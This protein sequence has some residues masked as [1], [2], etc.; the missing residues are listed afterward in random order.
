RTSAAHRARARAAFDALGLT[1]GQPKVLYVLRAR[2]GCVQRELAAACQ[3]REPTLTVLLRRLEEKG[4]VV[5]RHSM[6]PGS[7][8]AFAVYLTEAGHSISKEIDDIVEALE[9]ESLRGFTE[10]EKALLF[11][12]LS[13]AEENLKK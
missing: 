13:R 11:S 5:K 4:F 8:N 10:E 12:L 2:Q 6:A 1:E 7:K 3:V 9:A